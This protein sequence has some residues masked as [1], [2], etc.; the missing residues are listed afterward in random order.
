[1]KKVIIIDDMTTV[2][3]F[4]GQILAAVGFQIEEAGNGIEGL[5]KALAED[6]DLALVDVNMP[7]MDGYRLIREL[8]AND[9]TRDLPVIMISTEARDPDREKAFLAGANFYLVKP[10][11]EDELKAAALL[12][13]GVL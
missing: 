4:H 8:R 7:K 5:E 13:A 6:Y 10:V 9:S 11:Q 2:R 3:M 1:M 12:M